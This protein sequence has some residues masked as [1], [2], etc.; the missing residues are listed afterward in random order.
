MRRRE[1]LARAAAVPIIGGLVAGTAAAKPKSRVL[2]PSLYVMDEVPSGPEK[3]R[4]GEHKGFW[5]DSTKVCELGTRELRSA[6]YTPE[7]ASDVLLNRMC[8]KLRSQRTNVLVPIPR[9]YWVI[10]LCRV[11][12]KMYCFGEDGGAH[13]AKAI[14]SGRLVYSASDP[15]WTLD[16]IA[17]A[18]RIGGAGSGFLRGYSRD[19]DSLRMKDNEWVDTQMAHVM[20]CLG[21]AAIFGSR[22]LDDHIFAF[23]RWRSKYGPDRQ[24]YRLSSFTKEI[25]SRK[26]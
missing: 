4:W 11:G 2:G 19:Y 9:H 18:E 7:E 21:P 16:P 14:V 26:S 20:S 13:R 1:F 12:E 8:D 22:K 3:P 5:G 24:I 6:N 17:D 15:V 10:G 25:A 23:S